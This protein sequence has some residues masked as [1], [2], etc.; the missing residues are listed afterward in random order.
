MSSVKGDKS[1]PELAHEGPEGE[2]RISDECRLYWVQALYALDMRQLLTSSS[3]ISSVAH[4]E[5]HSL[6]EAM[7]L[8]VWELAQQYNEQ[9]LPSKRQQVSRQQCR[10]TM[11][12]LLSSISQIDNEIASKLA[13]GWRLDRLPK[14]VLALLRVGCYE[15]GKRVCDRGSTISAYLELAKDMNCDDSLPFI[16]GVLDK[17]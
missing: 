4:V 14:V 9:S 8:G 12:D 1:G 13:T 10:D 3:E 16:N 2:Q 15:L 6:A 11:I 5:D 7:L 17:F